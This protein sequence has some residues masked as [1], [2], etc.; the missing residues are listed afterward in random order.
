M[1]HK[2]K[3]KTKQY[4]NNLKAGRRGETEERKMDGT[5]RK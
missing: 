5:N 1:K 4:S 2:I 3:W